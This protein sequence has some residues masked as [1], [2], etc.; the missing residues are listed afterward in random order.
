MVLQDTPGV[1]IP[2]TDEE[3]ERAGELR[4]EIARL[5][6]TANPRASAIW[7]DSTKLEPV[8]RDSRRPLR[9]SPRPKGRRPRRSGARKERQ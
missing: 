3:F 2:L 7:I 6:Q 1:W 5:A 8:D 4:D 9:S